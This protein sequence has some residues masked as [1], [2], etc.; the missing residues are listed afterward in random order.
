[1]KKIAS[2]EVLPFNYVVSG[3]TERTLVVQTWHTR[4]F[5]RKEPSPVR[6]RASVQ[7]VERLG[8]LQPPTASTLGHMAHATID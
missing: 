1:M 5:K 8:R 6:N 4:S 2:F 7:T 3:S